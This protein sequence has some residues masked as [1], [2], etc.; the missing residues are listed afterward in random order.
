MNLLCWNCCGLG[1]PRT[2]QELLDIVSKVKPCL[3]FL[4]ECKVKMDRI[5]SV[6]KKLGFDKLFYIV[7]LNNGGGLCLFWNNDISLR[8]LGSSPNYIDV[9]VFSS[10][11]R[12]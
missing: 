10:K 1:N 7:G 8:L 2:V 12:D 9:V 3:V 11:W 6:K 4:M 5:Q